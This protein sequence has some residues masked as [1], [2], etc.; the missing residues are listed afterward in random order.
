MT[1][2][3]KWIREQ[4]EIGRDMLFNS[5][6]SR[7]IMDCL[8]VFPKAAYHTFCAVCEGTPFNEDAETRTSYFQNFP[9]IDNDTGNS[10]AISVD[11]SNS[12]WTWGCGSRQEQTISKSQ[13]AAALAKMAQ[14]VRTI[15]TNP[16][17]AMIQRMAK[18]D[19]DRMFVFLNCALLGLPFQLRRDGSV[20]P[21]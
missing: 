18:D 4:Y 13:V 3:A 2:R 9:I 21:S 17:I 14:S 1:E 16:T 6:E 10:Y 11:L 5:R 8:D 20:V 7:D 12:V 19:F 15:S